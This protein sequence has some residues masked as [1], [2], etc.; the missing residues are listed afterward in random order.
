M[1]CKGCET[2]LTKEDLEKV[3]SIKIEYLSSFENKNTLQDMLN[4]LENVGFNCM[5]YSGSPDY[6]NSLLHGTNIFGKK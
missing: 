4:I 5:T 1:D 3:H 2:F 6:H